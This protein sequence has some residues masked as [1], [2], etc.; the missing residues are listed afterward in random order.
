MKQFKR[1]LV[2]MAVL[3]FIAGTSFAETI[4][5][6]YTQALD[7]AKKGDFS[8]AKVNFEKAMVIGK[9]VIYEAAKQDL[10]IVEDALSGKVKKEAAVCLFNVEDHAGKGS[11]E[12]GIEEARKAIDINPNYAMAY[13]SLGAQYNHVR[14]YDKAIFNL[15]KAIDMDPNLIQAYNNLGFS[16]AQKGLYDE[17]IKYLK[18]AIELNPNSSFIYGNI[19]SA[20]NRSGR[21]D[22]AIASFKKAIE[23]EPKDAMSYNN[24]AI[25]YYRKGQ[26]KEAIYYCDKAVE[27]GY[28]V[29]PDFLNTLEPYRKKN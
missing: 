20:Y 10:K 24:M 6:Y 18:K 26:Y 23:I 29:N 15:I 22:E 9:G 21:Y 19:G 13:V 2:V 7:Y 3:F 12:E 5:D 16:Y 14:D 4:E 17:A 27:L 11:Y 28:Q 8:Q 25:A 1:V